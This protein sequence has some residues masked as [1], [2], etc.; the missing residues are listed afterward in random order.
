MDRSDGAYVNDSWTPQHEAILR[1]AAE[2]PR[3]NRI[4]VFAGAKVEM[5]ENATGDRDW[6]RKIRHGGDITIISMCG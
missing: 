3:V 1:A 2:D 5:C 6:L 4:F